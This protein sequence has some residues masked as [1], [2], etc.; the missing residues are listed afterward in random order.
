MT[1][2]ENTLSLQ[3]NICRIWL[4]FV[5]QLPKD[6]VLEL[7]GKHFSCSEHISYWYLAEYTFFQAKIDAQITKH[8]RIP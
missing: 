3:N 5:F 7:I 2:S 1:G 6:M 8:Y 4:K